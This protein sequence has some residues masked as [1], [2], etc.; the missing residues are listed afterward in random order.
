MAIPAITLDEITPGTN[1]VVYDVQ[2]LKETEY[3]G[4]NFTF[5]LKVIDTNGVYFGAGSISGA[6]HK[7]TSADG[8]FPFTCRTDQLCARGEN[9][10]A[11]FVIMG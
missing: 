7:F 4:K 11:Q 2:N 10:S 3:N 6:A 9:G 8:T 5:M 1:A